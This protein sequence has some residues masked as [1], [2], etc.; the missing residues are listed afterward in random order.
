MKLYFYHKYVTS[1]F[2]D[3]LMHPRRTYN[4][5]LFYFTLLYFIELYNF[6]KQDADAAAELVETYVPNGRAQV[7][8]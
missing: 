2:M 1:H 7:R 4:P 8:N 5:V 3:I 6:I